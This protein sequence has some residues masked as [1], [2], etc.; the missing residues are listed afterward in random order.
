MRFIRLTGLWRHAE[1]R[2]LWAGQASSVVASQMVGF[3]LPLT[4]VIV[5]DASP[6]QMG[7]I[8]AVSALP[9]LL[10]GVF[11]GVW[12]DRRKRRPILIAADIGRA[13]LI[14]SV[15]IAH[16]FD[17]LT[18]E[19][20]YVVAVGMGALSLL[21]EIAY[22]SLLPSAVNR[23][24][25][26]E[27]NSKLELARSSAAVI[28]P[29]I[30]GLLVRAVTAPWALI[31]GTVSY[32]ISAFLY[33]TLRVEESVS[34]TTKSADGRAQSAV[35]GVAE[36]LRF[37]RGNAILLS[38]AGSQVLIG[39][40][41]A[42][43]EAIAI[44]YIVR[45]L[46]I[47]PGLLGAT[48]AVGSIG[49]IIGAAVASRLTGRIGIGRV[50]M[51]GL[52]LIPAGDLILP[53]IGGPKF[54][55]VPGL[56]IADI[57]VAVGFVFYSVGQVSLRQALTPDRLLGRMNAIMTVSSR[58]AIPAGA[59]MGGILGEL[60]GLRE[61]LFIAIAGEATALLWLFYSRMWKLRELPESEAD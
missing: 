54:V 19:F 33:A 3:A 52:L 57:F 41:N 60:I 12:V 25:L 14:L 17:A 24:Q 2:K 5:L 6:I 10:F 58:G 61:T 27:G 29:G 55:V 45:E 59:L 48:F 42:A 4:A 39:L 28:G 50:I 11:F 21:F 32:I 40:F 18:I 36:G 51:L 9:A 26:V 1:F 7:L 38:I 13:L 16:Q 23:D 37:I 46:E 20:L 35:A 15:P 34:P 44:L 56:M 22:R 30:G 8:T 43:L 49:L 53:L 31:F 47:G